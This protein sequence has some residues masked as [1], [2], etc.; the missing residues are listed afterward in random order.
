MSQDYSKEKLAKTKP[1]YD[2][3]S[4][5]ELTLKPK[6]ASTGVEGTIFYC[7]ADDHVYVG[8]EV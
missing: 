4:V 2:P 5:D 3:P 6:A 7:S 1:L 8:T